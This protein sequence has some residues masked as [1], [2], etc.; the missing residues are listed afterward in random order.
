MFFKTFEKKVEKNV[1]KKS[2]QKKSLKKVW[3]KE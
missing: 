2:L 3:K 1:W